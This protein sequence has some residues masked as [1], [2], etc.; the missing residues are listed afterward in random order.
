L[1]ERIVAV[2]EHTAKKMPY[3]TTQGS[4]LQT[5]FSVLL[6]QTNVTVDRPAEEVTEVEN[7]STQPQYFFE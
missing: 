5:S 7:K 4:S 1:Y 6:F 3:S 2:Q